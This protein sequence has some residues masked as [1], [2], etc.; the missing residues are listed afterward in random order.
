M[1]HK[2]SKEGRRRISEATKARWAQ[3]H[4]AEARLAKLTEKDLQDVLET[5]DNKKEEVPTTDSPSP[6]PKPNTKT[7]TH[8]LGGV[9]HI[10]APE[11]IESLTT[12]IESLGKEIRAKQEQLQAKLNQM[13]LRYKQ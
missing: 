5:L 3:V 8:T 6:D 12:D 4:N 13:G 9:I 7:Y 11:T 1:K 2:M 10:T